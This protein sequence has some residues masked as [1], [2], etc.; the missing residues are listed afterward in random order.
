MV[1]NPTNVG[2]A[3]KGV[4]LAGGNW[5]ASAWFNGLYGTGQWRTLF[6]SLTGGDHQ[7]IIQDTTT[8]LG[9]FNSGWFPGSPTY[10]TAA[11]A[12]GWHQVTAVGSGTTTALYVDGTFVRTA[13]A[14]S[15]ADIFSV[16]NYYGGVITANGGARTLRAA[17]ASRLPRRS[18]RCTSTSG[19]ERDRGG[20][21]VSGGQRE[22]VCRTAR[23]SPWCRHRTGYERRAGDDRAAERQRQ[24]DVRQRRTDD[25]RN[26]RHDSYARRD[27]GARSVTKIGANKLD[28]HR[29]Q[30]FDRSAGGECR[31]AGGQR[32]HGAG[33]DRQQ[34][35]GRLQPDRRRDL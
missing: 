15:V 18:M 17:A 25:Q 33:R 34:R 7:V 27:H 23:R 30:P 19:P 24:C 6:R 16:G 14:K 32:G 9:V 12:T 2:G 11:V 26:G 22:R 29:R 31:D 13:N 4:D 5:T 35:R 28:A 3:V 10:D 21:P 8:T 20:R 1:I